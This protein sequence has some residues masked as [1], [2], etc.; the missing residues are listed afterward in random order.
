MAASARRRGLAFEHAGR[1]TMHLIRARAVPIA[2]AHN[3]GY[4]NNVRTAEKDAMLIME[5]SSDSKRC[6]NLCESC[7]VGNMKRRKN[8]LIVFVSKE[9]RAGSKTACDHVQSSSEQSRYYFSE[10]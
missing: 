1:G 9:R 10:C 6:Q 8:L 4:N 2:A 3:N 7:L 5:N